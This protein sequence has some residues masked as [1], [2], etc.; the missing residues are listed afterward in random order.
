MTDLKNTN[1]P[2]SAGLAARRAA[3]ALVLAVIRDRALL[4]DAR[5]RD[6]ARLDSL[7]P[8]D[9]ARAQRLATLA[10]RHHGR[11][12]AA[13]KPFLQRR[14]APEIQSILL[15]AMVELT[16]DLDAAHGIVNAAVALTR[17]Q[18]KHGKASGL[19]NAV[20]RRASEE[21][22]PRWHT[23]Q[24]TALP[25]WL[26]APLRDAYGAAA[27][28]A[29]TRAHAQT[30]PLDL[31]PKD[32]TQAEA[33]AKTLEAE[34]LPTGSIRL[35]AGAQVTALPGFEAGDW[36]VQ[37]AAAAIPARWLAPSAGD[38]VLDLCAAPGGKTM[39]L[40]A[41]GAQVTAVDS[42]AYRMSQVTENLART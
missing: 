4:S 20:L 39:Q 16:L 12:Q 23:Y 19:V 11:I 25:K 31:T 6:A 10:L 30:P 14:P 7:S 37:D 29:F 8:G 34:L 36:W 1:R 13:L 38:R 42:N 15:V 32:P 41:T 35:Q 27:V 9:Q 3:S 33:L 24:P 21:A 28:Q 40:A 18:G 5:S 17:E 26:S 2:S 22:I